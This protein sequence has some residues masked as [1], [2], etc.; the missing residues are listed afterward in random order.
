MKIVPINVFKRS[1]VPQSDLKE[2]KGKERSRKTFVDIYKNERAI[3][4]LGKTLLDI[5]SLCLNGHARTHAH[6]HFAPTLLKFSLR[7]SHIVHATSRC[8]VFFFFWKCTVNLV[9]SIKYVCNFS[10]WTHTHTLN[11]RYSFTLFKIYHIHSERSLC[12]AWRCFAW[13]GLG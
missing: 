13:F 6:I 8:L 9:T 11:K 12:M 10:F 2:Q 4:F 3:K 1:K 5:L 7:S